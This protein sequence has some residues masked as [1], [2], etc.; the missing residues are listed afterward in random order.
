MKK[1]KSILA[2]VLALIMLAGLSAQAFAD[3]SAPGPADIAAT[4]DDGKIELPQE[5]SYLPEAKVLYVNA[6]EYLSLSGY[7]QPREGMQ[8]PRAVVFHGTRVEAL[9]QQDGFYCVRYRTSSLNLVTAWLPERFLSESY[10]GTVESVGNEGGESGALAEDITAS[11]S[12]GDFP[13]T[14]GTYLLLSR[15]AENCTGFTVDYQVIDYQDKMEL[16]DIMGPRKVYVCD[17]KYWSLVGSFPYQELGPVHAQIHLEQPMTVAAVRIIPDCEEP[18]LF[19]ARQ[20]VL[21]VYT[22]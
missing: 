17:G 9:A 2:F 22:A 16:E 12:W 6:E 13:G 1:M 5:G 11:W 3:A 14:G 21:D 8:G 15:T 7:S 20:N 19:L 4:G 10:P 18:E